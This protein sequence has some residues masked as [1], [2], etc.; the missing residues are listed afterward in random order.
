MSHIDRQTTLRRLEQSG[1]VAV[2]RTNSS[3]ELLDVC[4]AL[5]DGGV[6]AYE[7]TM[8]TPGALEAISQAN[9][10]FGDQCIVGAGSVLDA[11][12]ARAATLAGARFLF[13]PAFDPAVITVAHRYD[14][15]AVPGA[16]TPTEILNAW[17]AGA[18]MV[19]VYP[20]HH[21]GPRY[22]K[23]I[24]GPL[25]QIK[26]IPTGGVEIDTAADWIQA[27]AAAVGIGSSLVSADVIREKNWKELARRAADAVAAVAKA[28][29]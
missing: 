15:L 23:D 24:R 19:K 10:K 3:D 25:P 22:F 18:D 12:T 14:R 7:I 27:G 29:T 1:V 28:R 13:S 20:A 8:T 16:F 4:G 9:A 11:E 6:I 26:L 5:R 2:I 17:S 21:F